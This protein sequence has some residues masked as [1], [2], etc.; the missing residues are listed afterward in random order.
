MRFMHRED[1][2]FFDDL[3]QKGDSLAE[4]EYNNNVANTLALLVADGMIKQHFV[5]AHPIAKTVYK[6]LDKGF[7]AAN[8]LKNQIKDNAE[9]KSASSEE[10]K[11]EA[12]NYEVV[13]RKSEIKEEKTSDIS[14]NTVIIFAMLFLL[15]VLCIYNTSRVNRV[16]KQLDELKSK[17]KTYVNYKISNS[18]SK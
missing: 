18:T 5:P 16:D 2:L 8:D 7:L 17:T 11:I 4:A 1:Q 10:N 14:A 9:K 13:K 12:T 15:F 3:L 6:L